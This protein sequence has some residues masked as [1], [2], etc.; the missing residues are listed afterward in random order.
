M[1]FWY[2]ALFLLPALVSLAYWI[3]KHRSRSWFGD[4]LSP[5][6]VLTGTAQEHEAAIYILCARTEG[7][8][9]GLALHAWIVTKEAGSEQYNRYDKV[10][11]GDPIRRN[12]YAPDA[13]WYANDPQVIKIIKG[14]ETSL[15]IKRVEQL[16]K[17]YPHS[18]QGSYMAWPGPNSNTFVAHILRQIPEMEIVLPAN[19]IGRDYLPGGRIVH[20]AR[21]NR[22]INFNLYGLIGLSLGF[23]SGI[24]LSFLGLVI[25]VDLATM[26]LKLPGF[27]RLILPKLPRWNFTG[28]FHQKETE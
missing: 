4:D 11:W 9:G 5:T 28:Q 13:K 19:A 25:G 18:K 1:A 14:P 6:G 24:E 12:E 21:D 27:G 2:M 8:K 3:A 20:I 16:I 23:R 7:L 22:D 26:N 17:E 15:L 10:G